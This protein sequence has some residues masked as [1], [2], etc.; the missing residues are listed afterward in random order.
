MDRWRA[1]AVCWLFA[2]ASCASDGGQRGTGI[3]VAAGNVAGVQADMAAGVGGI[4]VSLEGTDLHT[5]T[6]AQGEFSLRGRFAGDTA[7]RFER[8]ADAL[9]ARLAVNAPAGGRLDVR[10]V[11]LDPA[12]AS[13][14][15]R[16]VEVAF[17]GRV[18]TLA[19]DDARVTLASVHRAPDDLDAYVV[20]L[21]D[22]T[23][24][25]GDGRPLA[26]PDLR[27]GDRLAVDGVFVADGTIAG[28]DLTRR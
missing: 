19:C 13:A 27:V 9:S 2:L 16:V 11:V 25:D 8:P 5:T 26:C 3:T 17:E 20:T 7:L 28:A 22:A 23:L 1:L 21:V 6:D 24:H 15:P 10:D 14:E 4:E 12:A 18:E